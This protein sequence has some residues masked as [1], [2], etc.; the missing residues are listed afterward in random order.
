LYCVTFIIM[1]F[2]QP[3]QKAF[4]V[5]G[6]FTC[7]GTARQIARKRQPAARS[8]AA[9]GWRR[10]RGGGCA[11]SLPAAPACVVATGPRDL[12]PARRHLL[13]QAALAVAGWL[14][15]GHTQ[16]AAGCSGALH[17]PRTILTMR[18]STC[19]PQG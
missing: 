9:V 10:R 3:L 17:A 15:W 8:S 11:H 16:M 18:S 5:F 13:L 4:L 1:C 6:T 19:H 2:L 14:G 7:A 12:A